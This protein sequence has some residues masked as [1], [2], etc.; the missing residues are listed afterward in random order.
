MAP[1][2]P[3]K[4]SLASLFLFVLAIHPGA[5]AGAEAGARAVEAVSVI[6]QTCH[7]VCQ[8]PTIS[9]GRNPVSTGE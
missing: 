6:L 7:E 1:S 5:E 9:S 4:V 8:H 3:G 2:R